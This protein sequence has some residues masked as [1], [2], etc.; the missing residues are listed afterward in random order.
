MSGDEISLGLGYIHSSPLVHWDNRERQG[1]CLHWLHPFMFQN[2][3]V[4]SFE[5]KVK[6][7]LLL[8]C[9]FFYSFTLLKNDYFFRFKELFYH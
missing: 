3:F 6:I 5:L 2:S 1:G 9:G 7:Y 8:Y 4:F